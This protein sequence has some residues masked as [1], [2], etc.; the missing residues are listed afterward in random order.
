MGCCLLLS[1][2]PAAEHEHYREI[3]GY[4]DVV[5]SGALFESV[6]LSDGEEIH[7]EEKTTTKYGGAP[8]EPGRTKKT[9]SKIVTYISKK[10]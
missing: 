3:L 5:L 10:D 2:V 8:R 4:S 9:V 1:L 6:C 7:E